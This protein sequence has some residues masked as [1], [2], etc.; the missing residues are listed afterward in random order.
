MNQD[1]EQVLQVRRDTDPVSL[2]RWAGLDG[3]APEALSL[4]L[5]ETL[6][7]LKDIRVRWLQRDGQSGEHDEGT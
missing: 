7:W 2:G 1:A 6:I 4:A 3:S 5:R